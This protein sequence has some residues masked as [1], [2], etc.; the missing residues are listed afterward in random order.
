MKPR[1]RLHHFTFRTN[2]YIAEWL[3]LFENRSDVIN[4]AL[5]RYQT[6]T[7]WRESENEYLRDLVREFSRIGTNINQIARALHASEMRGDKPNGLEYLFE[8]GGELREAS[9]KLGKILRAWN[10]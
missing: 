6:N 9:S 5:K 4:D 7:E 1:A 10:S 2:T 8:V 3:V